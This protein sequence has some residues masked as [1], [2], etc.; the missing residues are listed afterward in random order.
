MKGTESVHP[1]VV[2]IHPAAGE[3]DGVRHEAVP[4]MA[5]AHQQAW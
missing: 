5:P 1:P 3:E 4:G 2:R